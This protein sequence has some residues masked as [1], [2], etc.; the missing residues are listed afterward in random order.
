MRWRSSSVCA[1]PPRAARAVPAPIANIAIRVCPTLPPTSEE[2]IADNRAQ[3][4]ADTVMYREALAAA[5]EARGWSVF[6]YDRE[7]VFREAAAALAH[8]DI[9]AFLHEMGQTIGP[10]WQAK[11]KL[12]AAA[13]LA[14]MGRSTNRA[15][16]KRG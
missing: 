8:D 5:A 13:A 15:R 9:H 4:V 7:Q 12:A 6:W 10:P 2:R 16:A 3:T 11:H 14:A 1:Q